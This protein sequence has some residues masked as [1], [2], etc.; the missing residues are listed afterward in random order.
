MTNAFRTQLLDMVGYTDLVAT[1]ADTGRPIV[2]IDTFTY[3]IDSNGPLIT[4]AA[5]ATFTTQMAG[6]NDFVLFSMSGMGRD[7]GTTD[8]MFNPALLVQ[9]TDATQ[10]RTFF[11]RACPMPL[12]AGAGGWPFLLTGPKVLRARTTLKTTFSCAQ[13]RNFSGVYFCFHGGRIWYGD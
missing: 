4:P 6:D 8:L 11:D 13:A 1:F 9:I 3:S 2:D 10:G 5:P 7:N 12:I